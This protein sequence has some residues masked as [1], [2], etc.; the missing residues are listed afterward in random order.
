M[1]DQGVA[2][3]EGFVALVAF[4]WLDSGVH[5]QVLG[6]SQPLSESF[7]AIGACV[8]SYIQVLAEMGV[9]RFI[10]VKWFAAFVAHDG[11][12]RF[13]VVGNVCVQIGSIIESGLAHLTSVSVSMLLHVFAVLRRLVVFQVELIRVDLNENQELTN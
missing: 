1:G 11:D 3:G 5:V 6:E 9:Q 7:G 8:R 4:E 12:R 2:F 10:R 13:L